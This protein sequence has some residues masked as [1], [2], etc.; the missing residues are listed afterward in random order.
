MKIYNNVIDEIILSKDEST[1]KLGLC[2]DKNDECT[3]MMEFFDGYAMEVDKDGN[4]IED[5]SNPLIL[6]Y[7]TMKQVKNSKQ[8]QDKILRHTV[9]TCT[10]DIIQYHVALTFGKPNRNFN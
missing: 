7:P 1:S 9:C 4:P 2:F 3:V 6:S 10:N 5:G 8:M